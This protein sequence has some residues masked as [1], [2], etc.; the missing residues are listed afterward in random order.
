VGN[1]VTEKRVT[2]NYQVTVEDPNKRKISPALRKTR[3]TWSRWIIT[4]NPKSQAPN[5]KSQAPSVG[6]WTLAFGVWDLTSI[7]PQLVEQAIVV[8]PL[9]LHLH[10]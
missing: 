5:P 8:A 4:R 1:I 6:F 10:M 9:G 7:H 3:S 2:T